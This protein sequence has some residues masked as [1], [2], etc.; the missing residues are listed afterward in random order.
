M[1]T[2]LGKLHSINMKEYA[3]ISNAV[4]YLREKYNLP[5]HS[6]INEKFEKE[7]QCTLIG[8]EFGGVESIEFGTEENLMMFLLRWYY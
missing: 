8:T 3:A 5:I 6:I 1:K 7:F 2:R 4:K